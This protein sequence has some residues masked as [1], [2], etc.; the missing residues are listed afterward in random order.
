MVL[1][2][3]Q[4][5]T[6]FENANHLG[7]P[8]TT[9]VQLWEEGIETP[10]DLREFDETSLKQ[11]VENLRRPPGR[12]PNPDLEPP[13]MGTIPMPAFKFGA[14]LHKLNPG[15]VIDMLRIVLA[16]THRVEGI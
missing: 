8:N 4:I 6:F 1:T 3:N 9:V 2:Q 12:V 13:D 11:V 16:A 14:K 7:I 10:T 15:L 5:T